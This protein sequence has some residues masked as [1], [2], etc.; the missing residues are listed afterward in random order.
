[1]GKFNRLFLL[2][3]CKC[4][5][6]SDFKP[7]TTFGCPEGGMADC[8]NGDL[9]F[10]CEDGKKIGHLEVIKARMGKKCICEDG[11]APR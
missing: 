11:K 10:V 3:Q 5:N 6:E 7:V 4:K 2:L 1:L 9:L 8:P